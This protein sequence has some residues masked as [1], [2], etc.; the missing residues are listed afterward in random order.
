M[1]DSCANVHNQTTDQFCFVLFNNNV[2]WLLRDVSPFGWTAHS[3]SLADQ[4]EAA[5]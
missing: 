1:Y 3:Q 5:I 2:G 4:Y